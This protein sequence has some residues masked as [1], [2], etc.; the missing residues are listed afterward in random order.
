MLGKAKTHIE[1]MEREVNKERKRQEKKEKDKNCKKFK[2]MMKGKD[3]DKKQVKE[4]SQLARIVLAYYL[5]S[6]VI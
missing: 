4:P 1:E 3:S 5:G 6:K 2:K